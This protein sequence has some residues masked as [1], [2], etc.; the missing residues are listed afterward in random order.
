MWNTNNI[1]NKYESYLEW[2]Q[3]EKDRGYID[4]D[5]EPIDFD[6][7]CSEYEERNRYDDIDRYIKGA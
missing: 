2:F 5:E 3:E 6:D 4:E 7:F 1:W